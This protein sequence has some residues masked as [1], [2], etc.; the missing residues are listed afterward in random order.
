MCVRA[1]VLVRTLA[2]T[3]LWVA[4]EYTSVSGSEGDMIGVVVCVCVCGGGGGG[5]GRGGEGGG[6]LK[7][8]I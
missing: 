5:G 2:C 3:R 8:D 7:G 1:C 4:I 6:L